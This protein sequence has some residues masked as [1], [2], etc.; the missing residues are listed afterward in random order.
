MKNRK[1]KVLLVLGTVVLVAS[2]SFGF[3]SSVSAGVTLRIFSGDMIFAQTLATTVATQYEK[4]T[5]VKVIVETFPYS[6]CHEKTIIELAAGSSSYDLFIADCIWTGEVMASGKVWNLAEFMADP[7]L[8]KLNLE[9]LSRYSDPYNTQKGERY[10]V[11][12]TENSPEL[13]YRKDL[14]EEYGIPHPVRTWDEFAQAAEKLTFDRDGDGRVDVYGTVLL[15]QEQDA[16]YSE[17][18]FRLIGFKPFE[19][20]K[21]I[22]NSKAEPAFNTPKGIKALKMLK[23]VMPYSPPDTLAYGYGEACTAYKQGKIAMVTT[24]QD[25]LKDMEDPQF[26]KVAG[27]NGY[28]MIPY[29]E[30]DRPYG[31]ISGGWNMF[32]NKASRNPKEAYKFMAWMSGEFTHNAFAEDGEP[33]IAYT[34]IR[35]SSKWVKEMAFLKPWQE[36]PGVITI[37]TQYPE[38]PEVQ[39]LIW[40]EIADYLAGNKSVE[41]AIKDAETKVY[42]LMERAGYYK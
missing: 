37:P 30:P 23:D 20:G 42:G 26:S 29:V 31:G 5:G 28:T 13:V 40:E 33:G 24:W 11:V 14:F 19:D 39:R 4:E 18:T 25:M 35:N 27:K 38:F 16:G 36:F 34:P 12:V 7:D 6:S 32:I 17:W 15:E 1:M 22:F 21:Y 10:G 3:V 41:A 9:N 2:L 8:P